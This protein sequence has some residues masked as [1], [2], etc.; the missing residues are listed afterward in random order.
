MKTGRHLAG[1]SREADVSEQNRP[2][3]MTCSPWSGAAVCR[4]VQ[5]ELKGTVGLA[6]GGVLV[7][8]ERAD[9]KAGDGRVGA[10]RP[11]N[12]R[13]G[14]VEMS[15]VAVRLSSV[16]LTVPQ[17]LWSW[18]DGELCLPKAWFEADPAAR[19]QRLGLPKDL[20]LATKVELAWKRIPRARDHGIPFERVA[21]DGRYGRSGGLRA[22]RRPGGVRYRAEVP[23]TTTVSL[24]PPELGLPPRRSTRGRVPA[25]DRGRYRDINAKEIEEHS[26][27]FCLIIIR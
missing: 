5:E 15:P 25:P 7:V 4:A 9:E 12:G 21:M 22:Q 10:G 27:A 11:Y 1:I 24:N 26:R 8:D 17:G 13:L 14:Q 16:N 3:V 6:H 19:R 2:H 23:A 18:I 20:T